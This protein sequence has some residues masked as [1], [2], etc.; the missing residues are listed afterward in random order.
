MTTKA[1]LR[2]GADIGG[3]FTDIVLLAAD[4]A[5]E[6]MKVLST[7]DDFGRAI[8]QALGARFASGL[9][10]RAVAEID[11]GTTVATNAILE[12]KGARVGLV[13]TRGFRDV[14]E[15]RRVRL[16]VLYDLTWVK[17]A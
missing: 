8:T 16:P 10:P 11:H 17:P 5:I 9:D 7:P 14:L 12:K 15:I 13:T 6:T 1:A 4:G 2:V 3:T